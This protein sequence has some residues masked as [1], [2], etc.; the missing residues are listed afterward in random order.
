[1]ANKTVMELV[2]S[3]LRTYPGLSGRL[4]VD[5]LDDEAD[6]YSVDSIPC[7]AVLKRYV[8]GSTRR[9]FQFAISS[10]RF[11]EQNISQNL[12]N[13]QFF[14]NLTEWVEKKAGARELPEMDGGRTAQAIFV[15]S[16]AYPFVITE[17]GL[18]RYQ[19]QLRLEYFQKRSR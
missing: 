11:Y 16:S 6:T 3:W 19:I 5:F 18:A 1:M 9:Q 14:E 12:E 13:L 4:D 10:R 15:T 17:N 7:E 8:D 2:Q